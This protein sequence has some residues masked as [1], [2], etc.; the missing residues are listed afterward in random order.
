MNALIK[1]TKIIRDLGFT[2]L[3]YYASYQWGL[4]TGA[5]RRATP[6]QRSNYAGAPSLLPYRA[7]PKITPTE[8][9]NVLK[10]AD[11]IR[12]GQV[13]L[14]GGPHLPLNL[15]A[16]ASKQHWALLT[17]INPGKDIKMIW[18]PGRFGWGI[19]L[20]RAYAYSG[21]PIYAQDFWDK[22]LSFLTKHPPNLG[23]Q[24]ESAQEVAIRLLVLIFC[25]R[26]FANAPATTQSNRQR[27]WQAVAEHAGRIPPTLA[28]A[29]AQNNN[30]LL[31]EAAG[32]FTAGCYLGDHP[33]A[34]EWRQ[35]GW[36][37]LN[38]GFQHQIKSTGTYVQHSVN[39]HRLM[40]QIALFADH[41]RRETGDVPWP[42]TTLEKLRAATR[43]LWAL[44]DPETG[45]TPNLG[46]NDGAYILPLTY[47]PVDDY[48]PVLDA[49]AKAFLEEDLYGNPNLTEMADWFELSPSPA[50]DSKVPQATDMLR[51][52]GENQRAFIHVAQYV[53]RPSHADQLHVDLWWQ[54][55]NIA[56]DPGTY[57]YNASPPWDNAF[58]STQFHNTPTLDDR[59]QMTRI[60]RFLW[61]DWAQGEITAVENND[62]GAL[63]RVS[64]EHNGYRKQGAFIKRTLITTAD[65]W[66]VDDEFLPTGKRHQKTHQMTLTWLMPDWD[67]HFIT[68][69]T[70]RISTPEIIITI[71]IDG[72][73]SLHLFRGGKRLAGELLPKPTWAWIAPTY[74]IKAPAL[75]LM[76][77]AS[78]PLPLTLHSTWHCKTLPL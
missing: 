52:E 35:S 55:F 18:E 63:R 61:L 8:V 15:D 49:A 71:E 11:E 1:A 66:Q 73:E 33:R 36:R 45:R 26:V 48:R 29:R 60:S 67:W 5:I 72:A 56:M 54:G 19:T 75:L 59:D 76:A 78:G 41:L 4:R 74:G 22:C 12:H 69:K 53:D 21:D 16:G 57:S 70:L 23:R 77:S 25:D 28:Y 14:F 20:A 13:R 3:W 32:L 37:W 38:W 65:G 24:W 42:P 6:N 10:E 27:L 9:A 30:H 64:T 43:W 44:T 47:L 58:S 68:K 34:Q 31:S 50:T 51:L 39:Y 62:V 46:A 7:F 2:K 40:L 17:S